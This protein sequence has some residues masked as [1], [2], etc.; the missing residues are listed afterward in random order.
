M[1]TTEGTASGEREPAAPAEDG[2]RAGGADG[3]TDGYADGYGDG[4]G[5][6]ESPAV[7]AV[8]DD[9]REAARRA[10][11]EWIPL[12]DPAWSAAGEP[13][14]WARLGSWRSDAAGGAAEWRDN[15]EYRPSPAALGWPE[16]ADPVDA[17]MQAAVTGY[18]A[19]EE[20]CRAL[21]RTRMAVFRAPGGGPVTA[22][23]PDDVTAV[24]PV[25]TSPRQLAAA[26]RLSFETLGL[27]ELLDRVP[28]GHAVYL[29]PTGPVS[30]TVETAELRAAAAEAAGEAPTAP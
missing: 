6:D 16:P 28:E 25:F 17:A 23:A 13:P 8:P 3:T 15:P 4:Y 21:A 7:P 27:G 11:G 10:P 14:D 20:V 24:V 18:G 12:V 1:S 26:G 19:S 29:N 5:G 9:I 2:R 30:M 22:L